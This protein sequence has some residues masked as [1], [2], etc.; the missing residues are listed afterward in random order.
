MY[1]KKNGEWWKQ[2]GAN[3]SGKR[4]LYI[5][6]IDRHRQS[7]RYTCDK[8]MSLPRESIWSEHIEPS[9]GFRNESQIIPTFKVGG[10][11]KTMREELL[12]NQEENKIWCY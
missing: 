9:S 2:T 12:V 8:W 7:H 6:D 4:P 5:A 3:R 11:E 1:K 10:R